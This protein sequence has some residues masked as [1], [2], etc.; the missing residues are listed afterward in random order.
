MFACVCTCAPTDKFGEYFPGTGDIKDVG[1]DTGKYY[2][3]NFPLKDGID[4]DNYQRI[5]KPVLDHVMQWYRPSVVVLQC[6]ADSLSGDRLG[7]FNL[8]LRGHAACLEHVKSFNVPVLML[9]GGGY[10]IRNV[11]RCWTYETAVALDTEVED[12]LPYNDYFEYFGPDFRLHINPANMDNQN[13][14][15]YLEKCK[16]QLIE[17]LRNT[18]HAP[19]T[20]NIE[21]VDI[22]APEELDEEADNPDERHPERLADKLIACEE[23]L[24]ASE[25]ETGG[26]KDNQSYKA[27]QFRKTASDAGA[28]AT[29]A[30][31]AKVAS[32]GTGGDAAEDAVKP[33]AGAAAGAEASAT[34][35]DTGA[36][37]PA[38]AE[39][40]AA[41]DATKEAAPESTSTAAADT[42]AAAESEPTPAPQAQPDAAAVA[43][44]PAVAADA[45]PANGEGEGA[46]PMDVGGAEAPSAAAG[47][48]EGEPAAAPTA[49]A[50][51]AD[52]TA[53]AV[54]PA[55]GIAAPPAA[56]QSGGQPMDTGAD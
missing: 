38:A 50:V 4:D 14:P 27:K 32:E 13:S 28:D 40:E 18:A 42:V 56:E 34:A 11:A 3:V 25:D 44:A 26:R 41:A 6:G 49:G 43:A 17:N 48:P 19:S 55:D 54:Q 24:S 9:G 31:G 30:Q 39:S 35:M 12:E 21:L 53:A 45:A 37:E 51:S 5:F 52:P 2:A 22:A 16:M 20:Q 29:I 33:A 23:E 8:S 10:T 36:D 1:A 47:A 7:C 46:A 15:E